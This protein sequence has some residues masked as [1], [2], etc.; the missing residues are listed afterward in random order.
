MPVSRAG[1]RFITATASDFSPRDGGWRD[2]LLSPVKITRHVRASKVHLGFLDGLRGLAALYVVCHHPFLEG[3]AGPGGH[4]LP[5]DLVMSLSTLGD[6]QAA[7]DIFIVLSGFCLMIPVVRSEN[8]ELA[9]G[10]SGF[11]KRRARRIL[12]AYYGV[13]ILSLIL[14]GA[15]PLLNRVLHDRWDQ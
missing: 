3:L 10:T 8:G 14:I 15:V 2:R 7:V 9:G 1:F 4:A 11:L 5:H 12:P 6:G 13:L